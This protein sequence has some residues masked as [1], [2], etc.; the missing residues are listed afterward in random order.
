[1]WVFGRDVRD[2]TWLCVWR[3]VVRQRDPGRGQTRIVGWQ[4]G[5]DAGRCDCRAPVGNVDDL[6]G[7]CALRTGADTGGR[8]TERQATVAH[9]ALA[10]DTAV[11]VVL[12]YAVRAI[13]GAVLTANAGV[14]AVADDA[15]H[16]IL[17]VGIHRAAAQTRRLE[18]VVTSHRQIRT[19]RIREPST[20]DLADPPPVDRGGVAVLLVAGDHAA[21]APDALLHV[22]VK[23]VLLA[24]TWGALRHA[25]V[26]AAVRLRQAT[27][28]IGQRG[29]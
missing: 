1:M 14:R 24:G 16:R 19:R 11:G 26:G 29:R 4:A 8:L 21:L 6:D 9:I 27:V 18:A 10:D 23:P 3:Q 13:P 5:V 12:R 22:E 25:A 28:G 2:V 15:R 20:F 7:D 17:G